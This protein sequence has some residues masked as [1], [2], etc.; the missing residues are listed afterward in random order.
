M[1]GGSEMREIK[2]RAWNFDLKEMSLPFYI[3]SAL[4]EYADQKYLMQYTG[5][6][7]RNGKEIYEG[8]ILKYNGEKCPHCEMLLYSDHKNYEIKWNNEMSWFECVNDE[9]D[10]SANIWKTDME[11]IGNIYE[12]PELLK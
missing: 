8:D 12:N 11:V 7:D 3:G 2:F 5:S 1:E 10:M 9:N 6:K 4:S